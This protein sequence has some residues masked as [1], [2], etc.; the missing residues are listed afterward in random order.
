ALNASPN[1]DRD[2]VWKLKKQAL[3]MIYARRGH[4]EAFDRWRADQ[5]PSLE[6]YARFSVLCEHFQGGWR[7]WPEAYQHPD[8][9]EVAAFAAERA[10]RV[11]FHA[12]LQYELDRQVDAASKALILMQ[13]LPIGFDTEGADGWTDQDCLALDVA[14]G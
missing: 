12:W 5:G 10:D 11:R 3:E 14:V 4:D 7:R 6:R 9:P 1:V 13:D 2:A 8:R